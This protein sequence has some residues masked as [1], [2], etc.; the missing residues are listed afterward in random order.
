VAWCR[1]GPVG[2]DVTALAVEPH[3][4][5]AALEGFAPRPTV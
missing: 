2:A 1:R 4:V 3:I 5:D